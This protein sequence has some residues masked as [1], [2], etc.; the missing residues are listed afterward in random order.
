LGS[1]SDFTPFLQHAGVPSMNIGFGGE[2]NGGEYHSI[3]DSYD[4]YTR[5]KDPGFVY[6]VALAKLGGHMALRL[7]DAGS[8]P[9]D[10]RSLY[11]TIDGYVKDLMSTTDQMRDNTEVESQLLKEKAYSYAADP[12]DKL[13]PPKAKAD[14]PHLN[15]S[16]LQNAMDKLQKSANKL[17]DY[18]C[19]NLT[20]AQRQALNASLHK[21]EQK[22]LTDAG[23]PRRS[24]YHHMVYA[25]GFY[26]GYGVKTLPGIRE[27]IEQ[28]N[29]KEAQEQIEVAAGVVN[30]L[31]DYLDAAAK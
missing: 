5:F 25:P 11:T 28:R 19:S 6:G 14:V 16:S 4:D 7:A 1:G 12:N 18:S 23:L 8:L 9:F 26:T 27:A 29:W 24:W 2:D 13:T 17:N 31:A 15:F 3:Y 30:S 10:Y 22:M 20:D 21:A